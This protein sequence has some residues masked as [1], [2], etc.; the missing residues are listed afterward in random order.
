[1]ETSAN[2]QIAHV[3]TDAKNFV[4]DLFADMGLNKT[5]AALHASS[6]ETEQGFLRTFSLT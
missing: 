3:T 4:D 5:G 2:V 6:S 1:M